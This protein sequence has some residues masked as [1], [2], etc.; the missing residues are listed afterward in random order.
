MPLILIASIL[1]KV[2]SP[3]TS[4]MKSPWFWVGAIVLSLSAFGYFKWTSATNQLAE[5]KVKIEQLEQTVVQA[6]ATITKLK[7]DLTDIQ[8]RLKEATSSREELSRVV[9]NQNR[10]IIGMKERLDAELAVAT[11]QGTVTDFVNSKFQR[12]LKCITQITAAQTISEIE[13]VTQSCQ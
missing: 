5:N 9:S 10:R 3:L 13:K 2:L 1:R 12:R 8:D 7:T 4:L 6:G 11:E